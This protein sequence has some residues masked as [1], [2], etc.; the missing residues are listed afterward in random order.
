MDLSSPGS[1]GS[2]LNH[3]AKSWLS[4]VGGT[5]EG[6]EKEFKKTRAFLSKKFQ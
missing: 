2:S 3:L 6:V 5:E 1:P 4:A